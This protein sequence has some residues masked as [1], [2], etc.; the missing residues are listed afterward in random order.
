MMRSLYSGVT[1]LRSHQTKMDVLGNNIS[2][3]NTVGFKKSS[4]T[5]SDLFSQT[6]SVA[7]APTGTIGG[8]NPQQIGLGS[9]VSA[10]TTVHTPGSSQYTGNPTDFCIEGDGF[11]VVR[12]PEGEVFTRDGTFK[13]DSSGNLVTGSGNFVL[14]YPVTWQN[15]TPADNTVNPPVLLQYGSYIPSAAYDGSTGGL[16]PIQVDTKLYT[17]FSVDN[18]GAVV[19]QLKDNMAVGAI[20]A[21]PPAVPDMVLP[22]G[23]K[24]TI[25]YVALASFTNPSGLQKLGGN[26]YENSANS[27]NPVIGRPSDMGY[28][29][30][31]G[32][33]TEMSNVDLSEEMVNM[34][35]TQRGFQANS[36][37]ITVSDTIL[38]EL[39]NLK[40]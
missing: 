6:S 21:G 12:T 16:K 11:F 2:N 28:G 26:N 23:T 37:I 5:F 22:K 36:R 27:G 10:I 7:S 32:S 14:G 4:V 13:L 39:I 20:E 38:E 29:K 30:L 9:Q 40:R 34:I 35:V 1:G 24:I 33:A 25:G 18:T 19:V 31:V 17:G 3:V 15:G 8:I